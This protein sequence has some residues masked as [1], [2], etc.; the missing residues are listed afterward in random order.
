MAAGAPDITSYSSQQK[1]VRIGTPIP[2]QEYFPK[3]LHEH[4]FI[5]HW[6]ELSHMTILAAREVGRWSSI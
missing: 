4:G 6:L 2:F 5:F 1:E 3:V